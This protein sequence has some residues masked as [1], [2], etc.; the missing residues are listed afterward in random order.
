MDLQPPMPVFDDPLPEISRADVCVVGAG[1]AGLSAAYELARAGASVMVIDRAPLGCGQTALTSAHLAS[2]LD[3]R[4]YWLERVHG[5]ERAGLAVASHRAAIDRIEEIAREEGIECGFQRV[6]GFLYA[7]EGH[8]TRE[9]EREFAAAER[10]GQPA[11]LE[12]DSCWDWYDTGPCL[13]FPRQAIFHPLRYLAGL[14]QAAV[15]RGVAIYTGQRAVQLSGGPRCRVVTHLGR[16]IRSDA[17]VVATNSPV[18]ARVAI[19]TKQAAYR[20]YVIAAEVPAGEVPNG[21]FWDTLDPYHYVRLAPV[22]EDPTLELLIVGGEDHRTGDEADP[23]Q[24]FTALARWTREHFPMAGRIR[25]TWSGQILEPADGLAFI[26]ATPGRRRHP[27]YLVTGDSGN[28][29]THGALAGILLRDLI[30]ARHNPWEEVYDPSRVRVRSVRELARENLH[31]AAHYGEWIAPAEVR[32]ASQ[33]APGT[34]AVLRRGLRPVAIYRDP[35]GATHELSAVCTHLGG[36][37]SWNETEGTWDCPCHGS[38]FTAEGQVLNGPAR[39][40][41]APVAHAEQEPQAEAA[42]ES[43]ESEE[44]AAPEF[45]AHP[46]P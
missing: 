11:V 41:L 31:T 15:R 28:G 29:L 34:G 8:S 7:G 45:P 20:T 36:I 3:D 24:R 35:G 27:V 30:L 22:P 13:R 6:D 21:L 18:H 25:A 23:D 1:I 44:S 4:L 17:L 2:A 42:P 12:G 16:E 43:A 9:L 19:H 32:S 14:A 40:N 39:E 10:L 5:R 26:G 46:G 38:R 37:V 33:V